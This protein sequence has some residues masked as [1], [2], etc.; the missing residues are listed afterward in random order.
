MCLLQALSL[1][2]GASAQQA[3]DGLRNVDLHVGQPGFSLTPLYSYL[4]SM[5]AKLVKAG[6]PAWEPDQLAE[7]LFL[8]DNAPLRNWMAVRSDIPASMYLALSAVHIKVMKGEKVAAADISVLVDALALEARF[9]DLCALQ[10]GSVSQGPLIAGVNTRNPVPPAPAVSEGANKTEGI[11]LSLLTARGCRRQRCNL[12]HYDS[13]NPVSKNNLDK[14][15]KDLAG[16]GLVD[17]G[18]LLDAKIRAGGMSPQVLKA[19]LKPPGSSRGSSTP[20]KKAKQ[21]AKNA[22][23]IREVLT[24]ASAPVA[25]GAIPA[26]PMQ[27]TALSLFTPPPPPPSDDVTAAISTIATQVTEQQRRVFQA[28]SDKE[29]RDHFAKTFSL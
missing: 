7:A 20:K 11:C 14:M 19:G 28:L 13:D 2:S 9:Q 1:P 12:G 22:A 3:L 26:A 27:A 5:E 21:D 16:Y 18:D 4:K 10:D 15:Y 8:L 29:F 17:P 6:S 25:A 24:G 23:L